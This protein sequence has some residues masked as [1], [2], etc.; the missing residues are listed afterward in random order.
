MIVGNLRTFRCP[1]C[2][3]MLNESMT[4]CRYCE[5]AIDP[6]IASMMAERQDQA[7]AAY[8]DA[9]YLRNAA[10]AMFVFLALGLFLTIGY[11]AF[12]IG[13]VITG[14]LF[15]RWQ[16]KFGNLLTNDPDYAKAKR[17]RNVAAI[18][19]VLAIPSGIVFSPF[20]DVL[21][22]GVEDL[23]ILIFD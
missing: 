3:E 23:I 4:V 14:F 8:S 16:L 2:N 11:F 17:S 15:F 12:V 7:N 13:F 19:L 1:S 5:V 9:S 22:Q 6:G 18:L 20:I 21:I 10:V